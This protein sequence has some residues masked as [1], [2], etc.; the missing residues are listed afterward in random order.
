MKKHY[1][2][3]TALLVSA[4]FW[5]AACDRNSAPESSATPV[6]PPL[7]KENLARA[8]TLFGERA[9][10]AKLRQAVKLL[11]QARNPNVRDYEVEWK[12]AEYSYFLGKQMTDDKEADVYLSDG[13]KAG[14]IASRIEPQ[15]PDGYFW[16]AANLGEQAKR[17]PLT[18]GIKSVGE[19]R[20]ALTKVI[21][22]EPSYEDASAYDALGQI[23]LET[24]LI[25]GSPAKAVEYLE[26]GVALEKE[27][28]DMRLHLAEAYL[29]VDRKPDAKKQ[30]EYILQMKPDPDYAVEYRETADEAKK[31]LAAK[32]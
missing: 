1:F 29:A 23:E 27:N 28:S 22:I 17:S 15:K 6:N 2:Y 3:T 10:T 19:I 13:A 18:A 14:Q 9:D 21:E 16:Y 30:L 32:F 12:F 7:I 4:C 5:C 25:G 24:R 11:D 31:L 8:A 26:K 20:A